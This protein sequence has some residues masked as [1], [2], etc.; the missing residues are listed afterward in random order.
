MGSNPA[1]A[2]S[3]AQRAH[4]PVLANPAQTDRRTLAD[5]TSVIGNEVLLRLP[6]SPVHCCQTKGQVMINPSYLTLEELARDVKEGTGKYTIWAGAGISV[7]AGIPA[8]AGVVD[9]FLE[10]SWLETTEAQEQFEYDRPPIPSWHLPEKEASQRIKRVRKWA[11]QTSS[12]VVRWVAAHPSEASLLSPES[13][14][15]WKLYSDCWRSLRGDARRQEFLADILRRGRLPTKAHMAIA[16]LMRARLVKT[17]LT[18]NF[19]HLQN[20]A[21]SYFNE[22]PA[23]LTADTSTHLTSEP[24]FLQLA[25]LHGKGTS[26]HQRQTDSEV[27]T[28]IPGFQGFLEQ[29][30]QRG[31]LIVLGYRGGDETP[32]DVLVKV[33]MARRRGPGRSLYWIIREQENI[34]ELSSPLRQILK[35]ESVY[36]IRTHDAD[37]ALTSICSQLKLE[38]PEPR[39]LYVYRHNDASDLVK[40]AGKMIE[41]G[42]L[43]EAISACRRALPLDTRFVDAHIQWGIAERF[44]A[45]RPGISDGARKDH[46]TEAERQFR[47]AIELD[48]EAGRAHCDL[49]MTP[50]ELGEMAEAE[51]HFKL[52]I[53]SGYKHGGFS[54]L[55]SLL[56]F[57]C[58]YEETEQLIR[59]ATDAGV[60]LRVPRIAR[61]IQGT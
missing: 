28:T 21:L 59:A 12:V 6:I 18:T 51:R 44:L 45:R 34:E 14:P 49:G 13:G 35:Y 60:S 41:A 46:L 27:K 30:F 19:D 56:R 58:R 9:H 20:T 11:L 4:R 15:W 52:A 24:D 5:F 33:I 57:Q 50:V 10:Q 37:T 54:Q 43:E 8:A 55:Y 61:A 1:D 39:D 40:S 23:E 48:P 36:L 16:A 26:Y 22:Y 3:I 38:V 32:M 17:M 7:A 47:T 29:S 31:G 53:G 25:Y 42:K 2:I